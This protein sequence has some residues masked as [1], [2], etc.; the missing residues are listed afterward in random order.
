MVISD[1][2]SRNKAYHATSWYLV[3]NL[4]LVYRGWVKIKTGAQQIEITKNSKDIL[5]NK[6]KLQS[7]TW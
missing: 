3:N 1:I 5:F 4:A 2:C 7:L 6:S